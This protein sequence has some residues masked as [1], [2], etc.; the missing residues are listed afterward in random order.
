MET[1]FYQTALDDSVF[2][3]HAGERERVRFQDIPPVVGETVS[4]G[5]ARLW[6]VV[7]VDAYSNGQQSV[8]IAYVA[9]DAAEVGDRSTWFTVESF[10][11]R[12]Q[13]NL[14]LFFSEEGQ[15]LHFAESLTGA[16]LQTGYVLPK[17]NVQEHTVSSQPWGVMKA[18]TFQPKEPERE[19]S[20]A[21]VIIGHCAYIPELVAA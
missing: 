18:D 13:T 16:A 19:L 2:D 21:E 12:P 8:F 1:V 7:D 4:M 9:L 10:K 15:L 17:F 3:R 14:K 20:Y 5:N 6:T 11:R